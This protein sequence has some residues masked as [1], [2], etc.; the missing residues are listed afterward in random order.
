M[1]CDWLDLCFLTE[2]GS[3]DQRV[4]RIAE[5][6]SNFPL[7]VTFHLLLLLGVLKVTRGEKKIN[8][9]AIRQVIFS[10]IQDIN[11]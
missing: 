4:W 1:C 7:I 6:A 2:Q 3:P 8:Y 10:Q 11:W 9:Y 5:L